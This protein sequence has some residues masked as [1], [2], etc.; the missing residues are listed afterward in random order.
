MNSMNL[1]YLRRN[2]GRQRARARGIIRA[3]LSRGRRGHRA[4]ADAE[5]AVL[6]RKVA[7]FTQIIRRLTDERAK[8]MKELA[9]RQPQV[10]Q[11]H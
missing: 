2:S 7:K 11:Y 1:G 5:A 6:N 8:I 10:R 9:N 4:Y 3:G